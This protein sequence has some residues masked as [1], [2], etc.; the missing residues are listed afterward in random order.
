MREGE[1]A[2]ESPREPTPAWTGFYCF[3]G[4]FHWGWSSFTMHRFAVGDYL[5]QITKERMLLITSKRR[6]L[7]IKGKSGWT[8]YTPVNIFCHSP[9]WRS[10]SKSKSHSSL[11][12]LHTWF[13]MGKPFH[14]HGSRVPDLSPHWPFQVGAGIHSPRQGEQFPVDDEKFWVWRTKMAA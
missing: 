13:P 4:T 10:F 14:W 3:L 2:G 5:L 12:T 1:R 9:G 8:G 6:K 11:G 7:Q